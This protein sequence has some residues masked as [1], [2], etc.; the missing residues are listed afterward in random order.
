M[1]LGER[2]RVYDGDSAD[3]FLFVSGIYSDRFQIE[4]NR[5]PVGNSWI[6]VYDDQSGEHLSQFDI[7]GGGFLHEDVACAI[8][9]ARS[10]TTDLDG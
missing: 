9:E 10:A 3:R 5:H 2:C 4:I 7:D 6:D 1:T 8:R